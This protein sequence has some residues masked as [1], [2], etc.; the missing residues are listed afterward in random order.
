MTESDATSRCDQFDAIADFDTASASDSFVQ[1]QLSAKPANN[2]T[3][4][5]GI[6]LGRLR[7][8]GRHHATATEI[9][10]TDLRFGQPQNRARPRAQ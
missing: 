3:E 2:I 4:N 7:I 8:V 9:S 5:A 6:L 1:T 10:Q